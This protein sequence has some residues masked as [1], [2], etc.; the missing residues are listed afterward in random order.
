MLREDILLTVMDP[1]QVDIKEFQ[2]KL[3]AME[4]LVC[5]SSH[6]FLHENQTVIRMIC[7]LSNC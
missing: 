2:R 1:G 4:T 7:A 6:K 5:S 3:V